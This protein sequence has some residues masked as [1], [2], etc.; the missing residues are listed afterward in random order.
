MELVKTLREL[1]R[2]KGLV[3]LVLVASLLI[4]FFLAFSPGVPPKSRQYEVSLAVSDILI[5][6]SNSQVVAVGGRSPDLP[7][8]AGRANLLGNLM[9]SGPLKNSIAERAGISPEKLIVVPP[10]NPN[11]PG[12]PPV[13]VKPS[14]SRNVPDADATIL[15]LSTDETLPILHTVAQAPNL[16]SARELSRATIAGLRSYLGSV[17][18]AQNIPAAHQLVVRK[19]GAPIAGE[20]R[21]GLPRRYALAAMIILALLG[22]GAILGGSWFIR[23]WKQIEDAESRGR[24]PDAVE[25]DGLGDGNGQSSWGRRTDIGGQQASKRI[26]RCRP[27]DS[28]RI[29][30]VR[31]MR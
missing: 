12:V 2:R 17:A 18:A 21:R 25:P 4:G 30:R 14:D 8:L 11:N 9:T 24:A 10:A 5:D 7:T 13:P 28:E 16:D 3:A 19:F 22:C 15:T 29:R 26:C 31:S 27:I 20:A 1:W 23:S 6:T